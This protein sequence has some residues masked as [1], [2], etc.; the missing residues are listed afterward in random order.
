M[1]TE[2]QDTNVS[3]TQKTIASAANLA[4]LLPTGTVLAFETLIPSF[5]NNG[6]CHPAN[7]GLSSSVI[8][9]CALICF[10]SSFTDS[11]IDSTD[12]K[13]YYGIATRSGIRI[14]NPRKKEMSSDE[15]KRL[16][17]YKITG[18]DYFH[19]FLA[20]TVFL[21]YSLTDLNV[22]N[23]FFPNAGDDLNEIIINLPLGAGIFACFLFTIF[24]TTRRGIGYTQQRPSKDT[25]DGNQTLTTTTASK[26]SEVEL[27]GVAVEGGA[28]QPQASTST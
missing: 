17:K 11:F 12:G 26:G 24:P 2:T 15:R 7:K 20:L 6:A 19:A 27:V 25:D 22:K 10:F 23:C 28:H 3:A 21:I 1:A 14:L 5:S 8:L 13:F 9:I 16:E 4:N 18:T